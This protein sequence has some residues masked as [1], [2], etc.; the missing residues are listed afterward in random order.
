[1][2]PGMAWRC[3]HCTSKSGQWARMVV[4]LGVDVK[5]AGASIFDRQQRMLEVN[6]CICSVS[7]GPGLCILHLGLGKDQWDELRCRLCTL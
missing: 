3:S 1:M 6:D 5:R 7:S 4:G 2:Q